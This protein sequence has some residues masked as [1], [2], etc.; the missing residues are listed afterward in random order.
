MAGRLASFC[1]AFAGVRSGGG[2]AK[3]NLFIAEEEEEMMANGKGRPLHQL[4]RMQKLRRKA[5]A[6]DAVLDPTQRKDLLL[7][8][9]E[10]ERRDGWEDSTRDRNDE[11][12]FV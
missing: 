8:L 3:Q 12:V 10:K 6:K 1:F 7:L 4:N 11:L 2:G 5:V 9:L